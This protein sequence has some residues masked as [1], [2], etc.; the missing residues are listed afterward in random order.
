M[1]R[2]MV[3]ILAMTMVFTVMLSGCGENRTNEPATT[4][5]EKPEMTIVPE[6]MMPDT[7][8]GAVKDRDGVITGSDTGNSVL[9][10]EQRPAAYNDMTGGTAEANGK[11]VAGGSN[12]TGGMK[13]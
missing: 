11:V 5:T 10:P 8:D 13:G 2:A 7:E 12:V 9:D 3:Y 6:N 4:P 1:K